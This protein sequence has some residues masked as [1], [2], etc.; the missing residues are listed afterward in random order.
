MHKKIRLTLKLSIEGD[1]E[2]GDDFAGYAA[3]TIGQILDAGKTIHPDLQVKIRS[4][5]EDLDWEEKHLY[6]DD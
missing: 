5:E 1:I 2:P 4:L 6:R 3:T